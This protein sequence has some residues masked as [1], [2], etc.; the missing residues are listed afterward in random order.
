MKHLFKQHAGKSITLTG[1]ALSI[2]GVVLSIAGV[3]L[4]IWDGYAADAEMRDGNTARWFVL[5]AGIVV[6]TLGTFIAQSHSSND[7]TDRN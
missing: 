4:S 3:V 1:V 5:I 6:L 7:E 2:A